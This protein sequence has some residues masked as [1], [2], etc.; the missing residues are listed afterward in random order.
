L[1]EKTS[2]RDFLED[3]GI[4]KRT[5][6]SFHGLRVSLEAAVFPLY[7]NFNKEGEAELFNALTYKR[8]EEGNREEHFK[9]DVKGCMSVLVDLDYKLSEVERIIVSKSPIAALSYRQLQLEG[10]LH[11]DEQDK[12]SALN[13]TAFLSTCGN[14]TEQ[15]KK[16]LRIV[17]EMA[18][19]N[20]Q[21]IVLGMDNDLAGRKMR[22]TLVHIAEESGCRYEVET[23]RVGNDWNEQLYLKEKD[24]VGQ[25]ISERRWEMFEENNYEQSILAKIAIEKETVEAFKDTIKVGEKYMITALREMGKEKISSTWFLKVKANNK[26]S[27][28]TDEVP[29]VSILKGN[30]QEASELVLVTS[31]LD[32]LVHY[33]SLEFKGDK[34][35]MCYA[36]LNPSKLGNKL[37]DFVEQ[38]N[39]RHV[40]VVSSERNIEGAQAVHHF[41]RQEN[42]EV[43]HLLLDVEVLRSRAAENLGI[44]QETI[45][46]FKQKVGFDLE[47][48]QQEKEVRDSREKSRETFSLINGDIKEAEKVILVVSKNDAMLHY[49]KEKATREENAKTCYVL[50]DVSSKDAL[51]DAASKLKEYAQ[52]N[53]IDVHIVSSKE[54]MPA[55]RSVRFAFKEESMRVYNERLKREIPLTDFL[56]KEM[57]WKRVENRSSRENDVLV[58]PKNGE[59]IVVPLS[60]KPNSHRVFSYERGGGGTIIDLLQEEKWEWKKI[61]KLAETRFLPKIEEI[62]SIRMTQRLASSREEELGIRINPMLSSRNEEINTQVNRP[63]MAYIAGEGLS[64]LGFLMSAG[65]NANR[66]GGL[67]H[68]E[69]NEEKEEKKKKREFG[70]GR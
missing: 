24:N 56:E 35:D 30:P 7:K 61:I 13:S 32:A 67:D 50:C 12:R 9:W 63:S 16:D 64:L 29:A 15:R 18:Q 6:T 66:V 17:F 68:A 21:T 59:S 33:Q 53:E 43:A 38:E 65:L 19:A 46:A 23:P 51:S 20:D 58:H 60:P 54:N 41:L 25:A 40:T 69:E 14:L 48:P 49:E 34:G 44:K 3:I 22:E 52:K 1:I 57:G 39:W 37:L 31:P 5:H 28:I 45:E 36:M 10:R 47:A 55:A 26:F 8:D 70:M 11:Q 27:T 2:G 62:E 42:Q 4:E